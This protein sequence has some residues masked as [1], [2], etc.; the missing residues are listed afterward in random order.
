M[1]TGGW[2]KEPGRHALAAKGIK[3]GRKGR[4]RG[5]TRVCMSVKSTLKHIV[6]KLK[7]ETSIKKE[8]FKKI[9]EEANKVGQI[10]LTLGDKVTKSDAKVMVLIDKTIK[11]FKK[12]PTLEAGALGSLLFGGSAAP[13]IAVGSSATNIGALVAVLALTGTYAGIIETFDRLDK[14]HAMWNKLSKA[15]K[16]KLLEGKKQK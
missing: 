6:E 12:H 13:I 7:S 11:F 4:T 1:K 16:D 8:D 14:K 10:Q 3:T 9:Q 15:E 2:Y 5:R